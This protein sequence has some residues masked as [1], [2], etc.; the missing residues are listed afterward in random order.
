M[1]IKSTSINKST[2]TYGKTA[3]SVS[4]KQFNS[5]DANMNISSKV[6]GET[7]DYARKRPAKVKGNGDDDDK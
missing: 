7:Q 3:T 6:D 1:M 5:D 2:S 4:K